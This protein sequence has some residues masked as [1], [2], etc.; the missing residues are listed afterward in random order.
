MSKTVRIAMA[1]ILAGIVGTVTNAGAA[2]ALLGAD[3]LGFAIVPG[4]Y[5]VGIAIAVFV[6]VFL[7]LVG[8]CRPGFYRQRR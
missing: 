6:P 8:G 3:K 2:A 7:G 5:L 4:R 1:T